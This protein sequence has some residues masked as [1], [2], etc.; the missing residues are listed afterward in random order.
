MQLK[1]QEV[2][3]EMIHGDNSRMKMIFHEL[4]YFRSKKNLLLL[5]VVNSEIIIIILHVKAQEY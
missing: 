2:A 3:L 4:N 5:L 1:W